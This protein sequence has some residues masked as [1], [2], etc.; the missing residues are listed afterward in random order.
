MLVEIQDQIELIVAAQVETGIGTL[1][2]V[3]NRRDLVPQL[4]VSRAELLDLL[5]VGPLGSLLSLV[6][7][8]HR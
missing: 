2:L 1:C 7:V 3:P 8:A 5:A 4:A 6:T